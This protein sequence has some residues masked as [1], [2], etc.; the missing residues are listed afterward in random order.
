[1][2]TSDKVCPSPAAPRA[3]REQCA[4][5]LTLPRTLV[6]GL[7]NGGCKTVTAMKRQWKEGPRVVAVNTDGRS[8]AEA[9]DFAGLHI[10]ER[11]IKGLGTGGEPRMGRRAAESDIEAIRG[12]FRDVDVV[13]LVVC[14]GG[15]TGTG[16][17]PLVVEE[18]RKAGALTLVFASLPF[19]F[20]GKR[21]M[22]LAQ[23]GLMS[24]QSAADAVICLPNQRL[25]ELVE[26]KAN[27]V[28][29][30]QKTDDMLSRGLQAVWCVISRR[31]VI[32]LNFEDVSALVQKG[33]GRCVFAC[34]EGTGPD[35][36]KQVLEAVRHHALLNHG[37][38]LAEAEAFLVTVM[39]GSD[40]SLKEVDQ[41]MAGVA[42]IGRAEAL[43]MTGVCCE[44]DWQDRLFV[45]F[46]VA[47]KKGAD[48]LAFIAS[49][50]E[51]GPGSSLIS[52]AQAEAPT[53]EP[54]SRGKIKQG[55]LFETVNQGRF[56]DVE[57]TVVNGNNLDIPTFKRR[58]IMIQKVLRN[59]T[60]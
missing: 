59:H 60:G 34:A 28:A 9:G 36:V 1:M 56:K 13:F 23:R 50:R 48:G 53:P 40:L 25:L 57:A 4:A 22:E 37:A 33:N 3:I 32:N 47:E 43:M 45:V 54:V 42:K 26:D 27:I 14:L 15:G 18:A 17:A 20:E 58:G 30:F 10:G 39:G 5:R 2:N 24:L 35:K 16:A 21:R 51:D 29:A 41:L 11:V 6:V 7:G 55:G 12:L 19:E 31:G 46:L 44:S 8:L 49:Q 52:A 38:V